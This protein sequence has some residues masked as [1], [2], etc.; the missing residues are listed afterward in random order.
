MSASRSAEQACAPP[1]RSKNPLP[2]TIFR[3]HPVLGTAGWSSPGSDFPLQSPLFGRILSLTGP[4]RGEK[5]PFHVE[6][7]PNH[8]HTALGRPL[9]SPASSCYR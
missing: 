1:K 2:P 5:A 9:P 6:R 4:D 3:L 7:R 8:A